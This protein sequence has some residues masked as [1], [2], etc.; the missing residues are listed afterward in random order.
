MIE[1]GFWVFIFNEVDDPLIFFIGQFIFPLTAF[2]YRLIALKYAGIA[3]VVFIPVF[4][5]NELIGRIS[6]RAIGAFNFANNISAGRFVQP[7]A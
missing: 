1:Y 4:R 3:S 6:F 2:F 5:D 7:N